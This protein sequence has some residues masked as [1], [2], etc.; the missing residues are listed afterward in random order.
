VGEQKDSQEF[1]MFFFD[2][3]EGLLRQTSQKYLF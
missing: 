1:L 2:K 3:M